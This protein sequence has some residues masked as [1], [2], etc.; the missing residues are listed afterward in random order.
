MFRHVV[1]LKWS[2]ELERDELEKIRGLLDVLGSTAP[3][4]RYFSHGPDVGLSSF[5]GDYALIADFDDAEGWR[6]YNTDPA[7]LA[8]RAVLK[9]LTAENLVVQFQAQR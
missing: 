2:R 5:G 6:A 8:V 7:H 9:P 3:S 1:L 4:I